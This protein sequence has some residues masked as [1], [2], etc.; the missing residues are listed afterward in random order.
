MAERQIA[1]FV[2]GFDFEWKSKLALFGWYL[3]LCNAEYWISPN[4][5][6][7]TRQNVYLIRMIGFKGR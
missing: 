6:K 7:R 4:T 2:L 3:R 5:E 1:W